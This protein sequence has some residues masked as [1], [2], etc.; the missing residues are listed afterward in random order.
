VAGLGAEGV[1]AI[2]DERELDA[3]PELD[4]LADTVGGETAA[5]LV[6]KVKRGGVVGSV[7]G[8][9][10]GARARGVAVHAIVAHGDARRLRELAEAMARRE[11]VVPIARRFPLAEAAAAHAL[12][13]GGGVGKVL[14]V[15]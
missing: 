7:V 6:Q 4:A 5:R 14:L 11:L 2:D 3:L 10:P 13:E 9:P 12:A 8:E 15:P 1:I